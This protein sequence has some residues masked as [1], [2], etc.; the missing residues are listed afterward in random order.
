M[1]NELRRYFNDPCLA[2]ESLPLREVHAI[3]L[4]IDDETKN[5]SVSE[6]MTYQQNKMQ[7]ARE[8]YGIKFVKLAD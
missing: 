8:K 3:R 1:T 2:N 6:R 7:V 4:M 5:M